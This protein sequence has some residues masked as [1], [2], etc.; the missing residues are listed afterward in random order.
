MGCATTSRE[1]GI[2]GRHAPNR[3]GGTNAVTFCLIGAALMAF[4]SLDGIAR[5]GDDHRN[6][7]WEADSYPAA[8]QDEK[9]PR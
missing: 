9:V 2:N 8:F 4:L 7:A 5:G 6:A 3:S 1:G